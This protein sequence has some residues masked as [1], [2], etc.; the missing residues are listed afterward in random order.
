MT[1]N[2]YARSPQALPEV[3]ANVEICIGLA[4]PESDPPV[5]EQPFKTD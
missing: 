1:A 3:P 4:K 5:I 2:C